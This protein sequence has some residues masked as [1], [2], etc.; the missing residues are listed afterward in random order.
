MPYLRLTCP[1]LPLESRRRIAQRLT[2]EI[3]R[4]FWEPRS[5]QTE[6]EVRSHTTVHFFPYAE[7]EVFIGGQTPTERGAQDITAELSDW[8]MSVKKQRRVARDLTPVLAEAFGVT[9]L[10]GVNI[11]FHSYPPTD[12]SVGGALLSD[13]VPAVGQ[14]M[15]KIMDR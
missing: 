5:G 15:K 13:R 12:F 4:L 2:D 6:A 9:D 14:V 8:N 1:D 3:V 7:G 11:R 10:E